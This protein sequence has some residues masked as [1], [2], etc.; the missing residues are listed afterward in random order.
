[1]STELMKAF[2][3]T[4]DDLAHNKR[5]ELSSQQAARFSK[6]SKKSAVLFFLFTLGFGT[7][8]YFAL[9]PFI[10]QGLSITGNIDRLIGG[11][12]LAGLALFLFYLVF[13]KDEASVESVQGKA[14]FVSRESSS[15]DSDG[16]V[17]DST[18]YYVVIGDHEFDIGR[19]KYKVFNQG[20]IYTIY[21]A[22]SLLGI[23]SVEYIG[24]PD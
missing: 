12:V 9:A 11:I 23:L 22:K 19:E 16:H 10:L 20:H 3:F 4:A 21:N 17:S 8:A 14:Q 15:T 24:S 2:N 5:G 7:G 6:A 1:M 18:N 13:Q